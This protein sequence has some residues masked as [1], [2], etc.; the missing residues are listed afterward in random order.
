MPNLSTG[1]SR[2]FLFALATLVSLLL[3][4]ACSVNVKKDEE[5]QDKNVDIRTPIGG[6]HVSKDADAGDTGLAVYPGARLREMNDDHD[7]NAN[8]NLSFGGYGLR[9]IA[10]HYESDDPIEKVTSFYKDQLKKYGNVLECHTRHSGGNVQVNPGK[11]SHSNELHCED[12][13][14]DV[15]ELKVGTEQNQRIVAI[16]PKGKITSFAL[17]RVQTRGHDTI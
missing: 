2:N 5:G 17:V 8:V 3:L 11:E 6:I 13:G 9:V 15:L 1:S 4:M 16:E 7:S 10:V 14:G 12:T